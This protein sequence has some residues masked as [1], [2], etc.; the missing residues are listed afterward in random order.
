MSCNVIAERQVTSV[1]S[2]WVPLDPKT[3]SYQTSNITVAKLDL[4]NQ[5]WLTLLYYQIVKMATI[6]QTIFSKLFS[7]WIAL[8]VSVSNST[9]FCHS[10]LTISQHRFKHWLDSQGVV[11]Q[12]F[13]TVMTKFTDTYMS[14]CLWTMMTSSNGNIFRVTGHLCGEFTGHR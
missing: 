13:E 14:W 9:G 7:E 11:G 5:A 4:N 2:S 3:S 6:L 10:Q 1:G 12:R 8:F